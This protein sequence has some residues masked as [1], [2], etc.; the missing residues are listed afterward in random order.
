MIDF[1]KNL[2]GIQKPAK[3]ASKFEAPFELSHGIYLEKSKV[4][5]PWDASFDLMVR[6]ADPVINAYPSESFLTWQNDIILGDFKANVMR[7]SSQHSHNFFEITPL[8]DIEP[9]GVRQAYCLTRAKLVELLGEPHRKSEEV[10]LREESIPS[11]VWEYDRIS[12][13]LGI[14]E[15][16]VEYL[17]FTINQE[18]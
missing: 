3:S 15:R 17:S 9:E 14:G 18:L 7:R 5:L 11:L 10:D 8:F 12:I 6:L 13:C 4:L 1:F 16:F 2:F